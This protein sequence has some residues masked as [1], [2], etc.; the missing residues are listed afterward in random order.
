MNIQTL[1]TEPNKE[2]LEKIKERTKS[3]RVLDISFSNSNNSS[4]LEC[5]ESVLDIISER[6]EEI[7]VRAK[8]RQEKSL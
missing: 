8:R 7:S 6:R 4:D 2:R 1:L 3:M 5:M